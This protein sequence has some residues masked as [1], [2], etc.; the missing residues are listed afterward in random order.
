M[1]LPFAT[2]LIMMFTNLPESLPTA[3]SEFFTPFLVIEKAFLVIGITILVYSTAYLKM[4]KKGGLVT[5]GPYRLVR[6]PQYFGIVLSTIGLTSWSVW[7]LTHT[8][9]IGFLSSSQTIGV[10]FIQLFAYVILASV[11]EVYLAKNHAEA[12]KNY[13]NQVPFLVPFFNTKRKFLDVLLS[14]F[15]PPIILFI[16]INTQTV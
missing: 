11:E 12:F 13:S 5:S 10:W 15:V 2:Y 16:L 7:I 3:L 8:F 4:K 14:I 9:G 1:T 6:H